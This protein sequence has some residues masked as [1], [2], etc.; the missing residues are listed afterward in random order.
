MTINEFNTKYQDYEYIQITAAEVQE[1]P[2][3]AS[4]EGEYY[5]VGAQFA[6]LKTSTEMV[7][8]ITDYVANA[9]ITDLADIYNL[10]F[11]RRFVFMDN[12]EE[13]TMFKEVK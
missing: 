11:N 8:E 9:K 6:D 10:L 1:C 5:L 3:L 12:V 13:D 2:D 7:E 4:H